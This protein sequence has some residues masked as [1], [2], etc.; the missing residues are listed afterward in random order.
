MRGV[1]SRERIDSELRLLVSV[2]RAVLDDG[3]TAPSLGRIDEL[4]EERAATV[5]GDVAP[6]R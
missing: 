1:R 5:I 2:R 4:L 3:G 6:Q